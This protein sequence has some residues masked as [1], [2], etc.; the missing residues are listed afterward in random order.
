MTASS[1][2]L[3]ILVVDDN[4]DLVDSTI[5]LL[6]VLGYDC[7]PCHSGTDAFECVRTLDPDVVIL[8]I[9]LPGKSGWDVAREIRAAIPGKRPLLIGISG[10][11]A[12]AADKQL[13]QTNGFDHFFAKPADPRVLVALLG[14]FAKAAS[15]G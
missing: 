5:A 11:F 9:G 4:R 2:P 15:G 14:A 3:R 8:D 13:A 1:F 6:R 12:K 7:H 10:E